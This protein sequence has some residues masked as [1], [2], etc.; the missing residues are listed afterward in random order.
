MNQGQINHL[1]SSNHTE[2]CVDFFFGTTF[3]YSPTDDKIYKYNTNDLIS[4]TPEN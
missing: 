4:I 3:N 1:K 2:K